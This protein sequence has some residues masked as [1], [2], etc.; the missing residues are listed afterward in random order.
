MFSLFK[1]GPQSA[2]SCL[3]VIAAIGSNRLQMGSGL[4]PKP[5]LQ[6]GAGQGDVAFR[7]IGIG[8][9][10]P[11]CRIHDGQAARLGLHAAN[12]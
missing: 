2:H 9:R 1:L 12:P 3:V 7:M 11:L 5:R 8:A 4:A 10:Q 6:G